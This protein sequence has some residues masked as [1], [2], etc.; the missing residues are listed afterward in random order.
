MTVGPRRSRASSNRFSLTLPNPTLYLV[1][2]SEMTI[3][4]LNSRVRLFGV[5]EQPCLGLLKRTTDKRG[6]TP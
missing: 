4:N 6:T 5:T 1:C 3:C 2:E